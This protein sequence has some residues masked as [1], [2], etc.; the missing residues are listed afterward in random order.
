MYTGISTEVY[1]KYRRDGKKP[2]RIKNKG[3][4]VKICYIH[5]TKHDAVIKNHVVVYI[6][7]KK[8][9]SVHIL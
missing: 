6:Y 8:K 7:I 1:H 4:V 5:V 9:I 3:L 2:Q